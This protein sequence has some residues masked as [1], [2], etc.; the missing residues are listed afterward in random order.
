MTARP[1]TERPAARRIART[2]IWLAALLLAALLVHH[3][4]LLLDYMHWE[5]ESETVVAAKLMADGERLYADFFNHH[6]PLTF[7]P[8]WLLEQVGDFGIAGH[9]GPVALVQWLAILAL[10]TSAVVRKRGVALGYAGFAAVVMVLYLPEKFGHMYMYQVWAGLGL[11]IALAQ[12]VLPAIYSEP[13][14]RWRHVVLGNLLLSSL[15]FLAVTYAPVAAVLIL[16]ALRRPYWRLA[17]L[18]VGAGVLLNLGFLLQV[19]SLPG[20]LAYHFYLNAEV[21]PAFNGGQGAEQLLYA[22]VKS[23]TDSLESVLL[24]GIVALALAR[25]SR[26]EHGLPWRTLLLGAGLA[27]LLMRGGDLQFHRLAYLYAVPALVLVLFRRFELR[28]RHAWLPLAVVAGLA[29]LKLSAVLPD[30]RARFERLRMPERTE[31][32]ELARQVTDRQEPIIAYAFHNLDYL[33]AGR[34][35]ASGNYFYF[36]WQHVYNQ[37]PVLGVRISAC[38]QIAQARP[39]VMLI[40]KADVYDRYS[41]SSYGGCVQALMDRDYTRIANRP[42]YL[43][44]DIDPE[45]LGLGREADGY[46]TEPGPRLRA[47]Q[48]L[49]LPLQA[50]A[51]QPLTALEVRLANSD[52]TPAGTIR[53]RLHTN[54]GHT[55][56][57]DH[58]LAAGRHGESQRIEIEPGLYRSATLEVLDGDSEITLLHSRSDDGTTRPCLI[59]EY[60][61]GKRRFTPGCPLL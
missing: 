59:H 36:P 7:L 60:D 53:L 57:V 42:F 24:L 56:T 18:T 46:R 20:Y 21:L 58:S 4:W 28:G 34:R 29:A 19:G 44:N 47:G 9:R 45:A 12:Y 51:T 17:L 8:G 61:S 16:A 27:M 2:G 55:R 39:K 48:P 6:G 25:L 14:L 52:R 22:I 3:Q 50:D 13:N 33:L 5:D 32:S 15:P 35:P 38:E 11:L 10:A 40:D 31:F 37:E 30:D 1:Q 23:A 54:D 49:P 26:C 41:W 43:R